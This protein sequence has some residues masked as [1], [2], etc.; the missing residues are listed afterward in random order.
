MEGNDT[1][2]ALDGR[3]QI[4]IEG[5]VGGL[6]RPRRNGADARRYQ[7]Q[8]AFIFAGRHFFQQLRQLGALVGRQRAL[9]CDHV[10]VIGGYRFDVRHRRRQAGEQALQTEG[11]KGGV[12]LEAKNVGHGGFSGLGKEAGIIPEPVA[13]LFIGALRPDML[14]LIR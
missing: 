1:L 10:P 12:A 13:Y 11:G 7:E 2:D 5:N 3:F 9:L 4:A 6:R 14:S 8:F